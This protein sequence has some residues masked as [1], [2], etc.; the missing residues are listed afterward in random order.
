MVKTTK[1]ILNNRKKTTNN[2]FE[3]WVINDC[4][5]QGKNEEIESYIFQVRQYG[6]VSGIVTS[7]IYYIDTDKIFKK[8]Y[9][10]ILEILENNKLYINFD[11]ITIN[12]NN[13]VWI[14]YEIVIDSIYSWID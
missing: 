8:Y 6:C 10:E 1:G 11:K 13:L 4:L 5:S 2:K 3:K 14:A 9:T 12:T 7:L